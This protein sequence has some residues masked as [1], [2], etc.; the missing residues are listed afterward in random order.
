M[1]WYTYEM[2][3]FQETFADTTAGRPGLC[4][5][6]QEERGCRREAAPPLPHCVDKGE[7]FLWWSPPRRGQSLE[8]R[9]DGGWELATVNFYSPFSYISTPPKPGFIHRIIP[10]NIALTTSCKFQKK[11]HSISKVCLFYLQNIPGSHSLLPISTWLPLSLLAPQ[12]LRGHSSTPSPNHSA[13]SSQSKLKK[14]LLIIFLC[15]IPF[16]GFSLQLE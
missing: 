4:E 13:S 11:S 5:R 9:R 2:Q 15:I 16:N 12:Q 10:E 6:N 1:E 3:W 14:L 8:W 7:V